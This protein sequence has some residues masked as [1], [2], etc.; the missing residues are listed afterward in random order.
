MN[1]KEKA[2]GVFDSGLGGISVLKELVK[3]M[4]NENFIYY[5]DSANAPYGIKTKEEITARCEDIIE[6]FIKQGVKAIVIACNTA[7][8]AAANILRKKYSN[9]PI[10]GMEPALKVAADGKKDNTIVVMATPLTLKEEK[11]NNLMAKYDD[12]NTVIK[13]P[14]PELVKIVENDLIDNEEIVEKQNEGTM[15]NK[16]HRTYKQNG[17]K[18]KSADNKNVFYEILNNFD[19]VSGT[20]LKRRAFPNERIYL[21]YI[22]EA[23]YTINTYEES[24]G[25]FQINSKIKSSIIPSA[26]NN[27]CVIGSSTNIYFVSALHA[28]EGFHYTGLDGHY[29]KKA[30]EVVEANMKWLQSEVE[31]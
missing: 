8:S 19:D 21:P 25:F 28:K 22:K 4:P 3:S 9:L 31:E 29:Y 1:N 13:M 11:F 14:C 18:Y 24:M 16:G 27:F 20:S 26:F 7:T 10:I 23:A 15:S 17:R 5:G 12:E 30:E 6:F 2:I